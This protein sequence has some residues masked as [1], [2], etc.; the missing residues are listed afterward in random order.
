MNRRIWAFA[1]LAGSLAL[2]GCGSPAPVQGATVEWEHVPPQPGAD[3]AEEERLQLAWAIED[4]PC[5]GPWEF[6]ADRTTV[7]AGD[8]DSRLPSRYNPE[9]YCEGA[10]LSAVSAVREAAVRQGTARPEINQGYVGVPQTIGGERPG[11]A[12]RNECREAQVIGFEAGRDWA[13]AYIEE[14]LAQ[15]A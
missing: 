9:E 14:H 11:P 2:G 4:S 3:L 5:D 13:Y 15:D 1:V 10:F 12:R 6:G 8:P 7:V